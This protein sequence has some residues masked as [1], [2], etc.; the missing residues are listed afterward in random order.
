MYNTETTTTTTA[1]D[2]SR[3][4]LR[5]VMLKIESDVCQWHSNF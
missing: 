1:R 3:S 2:G 4:R 5:A